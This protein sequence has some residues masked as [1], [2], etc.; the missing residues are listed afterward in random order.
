MIHTSGDSAGL[1]LVGRTVSTW[2]YACVSSPAIVWGFTILN[3]GS[4]SHERWSK[5]LLR[6]AIAQPK[7]SGGVLI[8][9]AVVVSA[10]DIVDS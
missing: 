10:D 2:G 7:R 1:E 8:A 9:N 5:Q 3:G 4:G 6:V